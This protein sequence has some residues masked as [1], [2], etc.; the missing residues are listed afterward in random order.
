MASFKTVILYRNLPGIVSSDI[1][2]PLTQL[3]NSER[4]AE[5]MAGLPEIRDTM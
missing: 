1:E 5:A 3:C 2:A 4:L